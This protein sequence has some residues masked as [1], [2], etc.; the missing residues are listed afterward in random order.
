MAV[1]KIP[2]T[3]WL[4]ANGY[5]AFMLMLYLVSASCE[6]FTVDFLCF[7]LA[8]MLTLPCSVLL[9]IFAWAIMHDAFPL[10]LFF[11]IA[12]AFN[13]FVLYKIANRIGLDKQIISIKASE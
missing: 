4:L 1:T 8:T 6:N 12:T 9:L 13:A 10:P 7:F 11:A 2:K 3:G 5:Q